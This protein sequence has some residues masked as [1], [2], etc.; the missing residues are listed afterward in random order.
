MV[1]TVGRHS[2]I[3]RRRACGDSLR[4]GVAAVWAC[5]VLCSQGPLMAALPDKPG[6]PLLC[7]PVAS[8]TAL[9]VNDS[10]GIFTVNNNCYTLKT[11]NQLPSP[12]TTTQGGTL[13][14]G[15]SAFHTGAGQNLDF[16]YFYTPPTAGFVGT[17]TFTLAVTSSSNTPGG[18][19]AF[20]GGSGNIV[21]TLNVIPASTTLAAG[22]GVAALVPI[23][24]GSVH[25][26]PAA[27]VNG[28]NGQPADTQYGCITG[29]IASPVSDFGRVLPT[30]GTL[31]TSGSTIS[32]TSTLGYLGTDTFTYQAV[33]IDDN[34][35]RALDSGD[36][37]VTVT[38]SSTP[39]A[40]TVT[41]ISP[42]TGP[43]S[44]G[45][46]VT[47]TGTSFTG[48]TA[49]HFGALNATSFTINNADSITA[50]SPAGLSTGTLDIT[51]TTSGGTSSVSASDQ[52]SVNT[53]PVSTPTLSTWG[54]LAAFAALLLF[55]TR[56]LRRNPA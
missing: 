43:P 25:G 17:D 28:G 15:F 8:T 31:S 40:P 53:P 3:Y 55:G 24:S 26:C 1:Q 39:P 35:V 18:P 30:H 41:G 45:T 36:V 44:G 46:S 21:V 47:I 5:L 51:V 9:I 2:R 19:G 50:V 6:D 29:V 10:L 56:A 12:I 11:A 14:N 34:G 52:F 4:I 13:S 22:T 23:P 42:S 54:L 32:Y 7:A 37:T 38:V 16:L 20:S 48:A 27:P 49:V 33:G